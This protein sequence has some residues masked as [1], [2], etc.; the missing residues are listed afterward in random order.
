MVDW[1]RGSAMVGETTESRVFA[2]RNSTMAVCRW[3]LV[4]LLT[5]GLTRAV[6]NFQKHR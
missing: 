4:A 6:I 5:P 1:P 2:A 3:H